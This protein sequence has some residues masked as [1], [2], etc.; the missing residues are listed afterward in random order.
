MHAEQLEML[1]VAFA[2]DSDKAILY[3]LN[4]CKHLRKLEI[5]AG[6][7][8]NVALLVDM[9]KYETMQS[10]WMSSC[11]VTLGGCKTLEMK[12]PNLNME[13]ISE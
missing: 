4:G 7:F 8:G 5:M 11:E 12:W 9:G 6:P 3:V 10:L 2:G 1:S 13:I